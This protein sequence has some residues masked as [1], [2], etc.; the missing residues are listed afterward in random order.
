MHVGICRH[1][2]SPPLATSLSSRCHVLRGV[3]GCIVTGVNSGRWLSPGLQAAKPAPHGVCTLLCGCNPS[4]LV[5][6]RQGHVVCVLPHP[7]AFKT[8]TSLLE[9][10]LHTA[11]HVALAAAAVAAGYQVQRSAPQHP[12]ADSWLHG[13]GEKRQQLPVDHSPHPQ[14]CRGSLCCHGPLPRQRGPNHK[15]ALLS[16]STSWQV[17]LQ[18]TAAQPPTAG[19]VLQMVAQAAL[20]KSMDRAG[21]YDHTYRCHNLLYLWLRLARPSAAL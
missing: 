5:A 8:F 13:T 14:Q 6:H 1:L 16:K 18:Q 9:Q 7:A 4:S 21:R 3:H 19:S 10:D 11:W 12:S 20:F 15:M 2:Q 17:A